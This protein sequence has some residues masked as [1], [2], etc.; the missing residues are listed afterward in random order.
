MDEAKNP[1]PG[2]VEIKYIHSAGPG[3]QNVNKVATAAQLRFDPALAD[4]SPEQLRRFRQLAAGQLTRAG[5]L[6][7]TARNHRTQA[8]NKAEALARLDR[9]LALAKLPPPKPRKATRPG[10]RAVERRLAAK[11]IKSVHKAGR[12]KVGSRGDD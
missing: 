3:G 10:L 4:L 2:V 11:K 9:L 5:L 7:I 12:R 8:L 1:P 6:V